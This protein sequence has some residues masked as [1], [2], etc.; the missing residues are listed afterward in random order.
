MTK[1]IT[2]QRAREYYDLGVIASFHLMRD[3]MSTGWIVCIE[4]TSGASWTLH[5]ARGEVRSFASLDSAV[6]AVEET[7]MRVSSLKVGV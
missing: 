4:G 2:I 6:K 3:S 1:Q 5:T 7:G